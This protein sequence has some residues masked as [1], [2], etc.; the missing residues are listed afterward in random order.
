MVEELAASEFEE[1]L[2]Y[3][4]DVLELKLIPDEGLLSLVD[5]FLNCD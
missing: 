1:I 2:D 5:A 4:T 3:C